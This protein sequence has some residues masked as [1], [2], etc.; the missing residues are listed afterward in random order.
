MASFT[1]ALD[2]REVILLGFFEA[3]SSVRNEK[4]FAMADKQRQTSAE[5]LNVQSEGHRRSDLV[6]GFI[7]QGL[8]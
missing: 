2:K 7:R 8:K 5:L 6:F 3:K 1:F 4:S